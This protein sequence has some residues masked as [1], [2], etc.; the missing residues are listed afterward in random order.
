MRSVSSV[1]FNDRLCHRCVIIVGDDDGGI[2][3]VIGFNVGVV[4]GGPVGTVIFCGVYAYMTNV[5]LLLIGFISIFFYTA[6]GII[7]AIV[8]TISTAI[9]AT[10]TAIVAIAIVATVSTTVVTTVA[11][12]ATSTV[13]ISTVAVIVVI[14]VH[15]C[16][17]VVVH[18]KL[19]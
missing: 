9:V 12:V 15:S 7:V 17:L 16:E 10:V 6:I 11:I 3:S 8:I 4:C 19:S 14:I 1:L 5:L 2:G 18:I 13:I